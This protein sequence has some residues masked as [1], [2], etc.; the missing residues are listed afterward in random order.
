MGF[1]KPYFKHTSIEKN[2]K[3]T[4][5]VHVYVF[6]ENYRQLLRVLNFYTLNPEAPRHSYGNDQHTQF[7][8]FLLELA[9]LASNY[10]F[11]AKSL[12]QYIARFHPDAVALLQHPVGYFVKDLQSLTLEYTLPIVLEAAQTSSPVPAI[13]FDKKRLMTWPHWQPEARKF[14]ESQ[15]A[16]FDVQD[17]INL[18]ATLTL[19]AQ[20]TFQDLKS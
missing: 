19:D 1:T 14:L 3:S 6:E 10:F 13:Y 20:M 5:D 17:V 11:A 8:L 9:R 7:N 4:F 18:Y 15:D 16:Y 2:T 12:N